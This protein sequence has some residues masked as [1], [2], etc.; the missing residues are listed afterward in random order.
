[1]LPADENQNRTYDKGH[2]LKK[3]F[4]L[5]NHLDSLPK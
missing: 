5:Y 2:M 1:M 3:E 4:S